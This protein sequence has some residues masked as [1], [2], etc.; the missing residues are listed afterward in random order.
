[1]KPALAS[2]IVWHS[3]QAPGRHSF[4]YRMTYLWCDVDALDRGEA[5]PPWIGAGPRGLLQVRRRDH[6]EGTDGNWR[7]G[8]EGWLAQAGIASAPTI[9]LLTLPSLLGR[10]F[11]PVGFWIGRD[12]EGGVRWMVAEVDNTFGERHL[13]PLDAKAC[14]DGRL[15]WTA[16][17]AFS[18]SPFHG[19]EG[20]YE[21]RLD[22][23]ESGIGIGIDLRRHGEGVFRTGL[24]LEFREFGTRE[25]V[26][27]LAALAASV[28]LTVPR[29]LWQAARIHFAGKARARPHPDGND[30]WTIRRGKAVLLQRLFA[31]PALGRVWTGLGRILTSSRNDQPGGRAHGT[32]IRHLI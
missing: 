6:L 12:A 3:R 16:P 23:K 32:G 29:I 26:R 30:P 11:N 4:S 20:E 10:T 21:F 22:L 2:G 19:V 15:V 14:P 8:I 28:A 18:V 27:S 7:E 1:M 25:M 31:N 24:A 13:Y 9:H 5:A 17:K